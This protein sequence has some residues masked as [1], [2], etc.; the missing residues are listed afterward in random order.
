MFSKRQL[1]INEVKN[2]EN[3]HGKHE[4][5]LGYNHSATEEFLGHPIIHEYL[6][7]DENQDPELDYDAKSPDRSDYYE[8][9]IRKLLPHKFSN[10][11]MYRYHGED[12][13]VMRSLEKKF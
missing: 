4:D 5:W 8:L 1:F 3:K 13:N 11:R 10:Q 7:R 9:R 12:I 6:Y 2:F